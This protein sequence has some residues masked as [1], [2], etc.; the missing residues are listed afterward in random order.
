MLHGE[1]KKTVSK[2]ERLQ[3]NAAPPVFTRSRATSFDTVQHIS[4]MSQSA[5]EDLEGGNRAGVSYLSLR[6][7]F[8]KFTNHKCYAAVHIDA[9][10]TQQRISN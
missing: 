6:P 8:S 10:Q 1:D 2:Q 7:V 4:S 5:R 3:S 9:D